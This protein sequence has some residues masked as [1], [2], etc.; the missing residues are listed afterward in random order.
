MPEA[1]ALLAKIRSRID[2]KRFRDQHWEGS[3]EDYLKLV[4]ANP[5]IARSSY[6]RIYDM[7]LHFPWAGISDGSPC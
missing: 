1:D 6:Q 5:A 7:I 4:I 3:F 2:P